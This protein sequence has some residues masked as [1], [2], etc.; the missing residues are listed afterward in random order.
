M[1]GAYV[2]DLYDGSMLHVCMPQVEYVSAGRR[3][4]E[5]RMKRRA[6]REGRHEDF[7]TDPGA[8][9]YTIRLASW[10]LGHVVGNCFFIHHIFSVKSAISLIR[11]T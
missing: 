3:R 10:R 11:N 5:E 2:M 6:K 7:Y 4:Y 8:P 9:S 1:H